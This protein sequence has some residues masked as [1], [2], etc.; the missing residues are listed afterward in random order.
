[1]EGPEDDKAISE[2][3]MTWLDI[4]NIMSFST[5]L[6]FNGYMVVNYL[7]KKKKYELTYLISFYSLTFALAISKICM[8]ITLLRYREGEKVYQDYIWY[9]SGEIGP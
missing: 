1:M 5:L 7:I 2:K 9:I 3:L 6:L 8:F 4:F